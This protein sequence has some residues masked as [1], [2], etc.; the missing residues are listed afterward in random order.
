MG[1]TIFKMK[2]GIMPILR[3]DEDETL[4]DAIAA[5]TIIATV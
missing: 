3:M 2:R 4:G 5:V 1:T